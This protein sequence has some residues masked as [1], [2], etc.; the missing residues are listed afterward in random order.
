MKI[1]QRLLVFMVLIAMGAAYFIANQLSFT[2]VFQDI[3][4]LELFLVFL[5]A[6]YSVMFHLVLHELG[7]LF[8]GW[9]TGY[10]LLYL[11]LP[12]FQYDAN[13]KT[14]TRKNRQSPGLA[15]QCLMAP[16]TDKQPYLLYLAGGL[17][18]NLLTAG[19]LYGGAFFLEGKWSVF[20]F[21][22]SLVPMYLFLANALP[23]GLS[24]GLTISQI[25]KSP[26]EKQL[27]F[28]QMTVVAL[29]KSGKTY[30]ELDADYFTE[31]KS[32]QAQTSLLGEYL[33]LIYY[34]QLLEKLDF[35]EAD[36]ILTS[37]TS[38]ESYLKSPYV[39]II[40]VEKVFCN[41]VFGRKDA[42]QADMTIIEEY[43]AL[44]NYYSRVAI[45]QAAYALFIEKDIEKAH[46]LIPT[47]DEKAERLFTKAE[48]ELNRQL[49]EWLKSYTLTV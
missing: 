40:M 46:Q 42:V 3:P 14:P 36:K 19:F 43:P 48:L 1:G 29:L 22:F 37:L 8:F 38:K 10:K 11:Q 45:P 12:F 47:I 20:A 23:Y 35:P 17:I 6:L 39:R 13:S 7:H 2:V 5:L 9:L 32:G 34:Q 28:K 18:V 49:S 4:F 27:Y 21:I 25:S 26:L 33:V 41:A 16:P 15:G 30:G 24:D 31:V 44:K